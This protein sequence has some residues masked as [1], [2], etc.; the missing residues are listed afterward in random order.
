LKNSQGVAFSRWHSNIIKMK[1]ADEKQTA[2]NAMAALKRDHLSYVEDKIKQVEQNNAWKYSLSKIISAFRGVLKRGCRSA[3]RTWHRAVMLMDAADRQRNDER[4]QFKKNVRIG[5]ARLVRFINRLFRN[6]VGRMFSTWNINVLRMNDM[7]ALND[8]SETRDNILMLEMRNENSVKLES[9]RKRFQE[10]TRELRMNAKTLERKVQ[11]QDTLIK[12][13]K[14]V[15]ETTKK[16]VS[17]LTEKLRHAN[18]HRDR[19]L[20]EVKRGQEDLQLFKQ[21]HGGSKDYGSVAEVEF[22][23][24]QQLSEIARLRSLWVSAENTRVEEGKRCMGLLVQLKRDHEEKLAS[25]ES[26]NSMLLADINQKSNTIETMEAEHEFEQRRLQ[27]K[28]VTLKTSFKERLQAAHD[29]L[30]K[31]RT[32]EIDALERLHCAEKEKLQENIVNIKEQVQNNV[33]FMA[34]R[35]I[36]SIFASK[37]RVGQLAKALKKW[38]CAM[39]A[40]HMQTQYAQKRTHDHS[41]MA[42]SMCNI[43][44]LQ[45]Q[46]FFFQNWAKKSFQLRK[47][48]SFMRILLARKHRS[49]FE[50]TWTQW[51]FFC[52]KVSI[53]T[54]YVGDI[55]SLKAEYGQYKQRVV[56]NRVLAYLG[57]EKR[58]QMTRCILQWRQYVTRLRMQRNN[59]RSIFCKVR[60]HCL[61]ESFKRLLYQKNASVLQE[62]FDNHSLSMKNLVLKNAKQTA[63]LR[64][65]DILSCL[66]RK[67]EN[68]QVSTYF[69]HIK[70]EAIRFQRMKSFLS[71]K[72]LARHRACTARPF[73]ILFRGCMREKMKEKSIR[74]QKQLQADMEFEFETQ[75]HE[76]INKYE[77]QL[78][79]S[80]ELYDQ[81]EKA[82]KEDFESQIIQTKDRFEEKILQRCRVLIEQFQY[83]QE[84]RITVRIFQSWRTCSRQ[85][86]RK[87]F[88]MCTM[89]SQFNNTLLL[90]GMRCWKDMSNNIHLFKKAELNAKCW[91]DMKKQAKQTQLCRLFR[92]FHY[93][94]LRT[95]LH[96]LS[97]RTKMLALIQDSARA[98]KKLEDFHALSLEN[99][100]SET[101]SELHKQHAAILTS[102]EEAFEQRLKNES[103]AAETLLRK[104]QEGAEHESIRLQ[105]EH[106]RKMEELH[107]CLSSKWHEEKTALVLRHQEEQEKAALVASIRYSDVE[108]ELQRA[109]HQRQLLEVEV[110]KEKR[111]SAK[112]KEKLETVIAR[113]TAS[114]SSKVDI[115]ELQHSDAI[116]EIKS[117]HRQEMINNIQQLQEKHAHELKL[118]KTRLEGLHA[119]ALAS[120]MASFEKH[121]SAKLN[122][123]FSLQK[124]QYEDT[125]VAKMKALVETHDERLR[126]ALDRA[127]LEHDIDTTRKLEKQKGEM[128]AHIKLLESNHRSEV[129][130][131]DA[132][133]QRALFSLKQQCQCE[134]E[135]M[136]ATYTAQKN[137]LELQCAQTLS[138]NA[139]K[140]QEEK[141][142]FKS[143]SQINFAKK[144]QT[145]EDEYNR[146]TELLLSKNERECKEYSERLICMRKDFSK[147]KEEIVTKMTASEKAAIERVRI[148]FES[149]LSLQKYQAE[150]RAKQN[151]NKRLAEAIA[152]L[153]SNIRQLH[154]DLEQQRISSVAS[155]EELKLQLKREWEE[156]LKLSLIER[157]DAVSKALITKFT[158][159]KTELEHK[160][161]GIYLK[162]EIAL[163]NVVANLEA[164]QK[165]LISE[166]QRTAELH[167]SKMAD[168]RSKLQTWESEMDLERHATREKME[169]MERTFQENIKQAV[170]NITGLKDREI[171]EITERR[172]RATHEHEKEKQ[173]LEKKLTEELRLAA[174]RRVQV[175]KEEAASQ[176]LVAESKWKSKLEEQVKSH[177]LHIRDLEQRF[178]FDLA[179]AAVAQTAAISR[180]KDAH[181]KSM[182]KLKLDHA[183]VLEDIKK[184]TELAKRGLQQRHSD[185]VAF[186]LKTMEASAENKLREKTLAL[187]QALQEDARREKE[188][189][190]H[191]LNVEWT[192]KLNEAMCEAE[193]KRTAALEQLQQVHKEETKSALINL[194]MQQECV[195]NQ[196]IDTTTARLQHKVDVVVEEQKH[197]TT[198]FAKEAQDMAR[199]HQDQVTRLQKELAEKEWKIQEGIQ[200]LDVQNKRKGLEL[201]SLSLKHVH[202]IKEMRIKLSKEH[203]EALIN[204]KREHAILIDAERERA[205]SESKIA[206]EAKLKEARNS[207]E[208]KFSLSLKG[209]TQRYEKSLNE[210]DADIGRLNATVSTLQALQPENEHLRK[211]LLTLAQKI[212]TLESSLASLDAEKV[213]VET[214]RQ[215]DIDWHKSE[216]ERC[217]SLWDAEKKQLQK[218]FEHDV[219]MCEEKNDLMRR[220]DL[221]DQAKEVRKHCEQESRVKLDVL[222]RQVGQQFI[223]EQNVMNENWASL[224]A[225]LA[226]KQALTEKDVSN[227]VLRMSQERSKLQVLLNRERALAA[228]TLRTQELTR[229]KQEVLFQKISQRYRDAIHTLYQ[230]KFAGKRTLT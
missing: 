121:T 52:E 59:L 50:S 183:T 220:K 10:D 197:Q 158:H 40:L 223:H 17:G 70:T 198:Q 148:E 166:L 150:D 138:D 19:L 212:Q 24:V 189:L 88:L 209:I 151:T 8:A 126:Q 157:E 218:Q 129:D 140:L 64:Q 131:L 219:Q 211:E 49:I 190:R 61:S 106:K 216:H 161:V 226:E 32:R 199:K 122:A 134:K 5:R 83:K 225:K 133:H 78:K 81:Q 33:K 192:T 98:K 41:R 187:K 69:N 42:L 113:V 127:Q 21:I 202:E 200:E 207:Y 128:E 162:K 25:L 196:S 57:L 16:E 152:P 165:K 80:Q 132:G 101:K 146:K 173:H 230:D 23:K 154:V 56:E 114:C 109:K 35:R 11:Q 31:T 135:A 27:N 30:F 156:R 171:Q 62:T 84:A 142:A 217:V 76:I 175:A 180:E 214:Q 14:S 20:E 167:A 181:D 144:L 15:A 159:E 87:T 29:D 184:N 201:Q 163:K 72:L 79:L 85:R 97:T 43:R 203:S 136:L 13:W 116:A 92:F 46:A 102:K 160:L 55:D 60:K 139:T 172:L 182:E 123:S 37:D 36:Y 6:K 51:R 96:Q 90:K 82:M 149:K 34:G 99:A 170:E 73:Q 22:E 9:Q 107:Q 103:I 213:K 153:E 215:K 100:V 94:T 188:Q 66:L 111:E 164:E 120:S 125:N 224:I 18:D 12:H 145:K 65:Q 177:Q 2:D 178:K 204:L 67:I 108:K 3:F 26:K 115:L 58:S 141:N 206:Y 118:E 44:S 185:E 222:M 208:N 77:K 130:A 147:E 221:H 191:T 48:K 28:I 53:S 1:F 143:D 137:S 93:G 193:K 227:L 112:E 186:K 7:K 71:R 105:S 168:S 174:D 195:H 229:K 95:A 63:Y 39:S 228:Q 91:Q 54:R 119:D 110:E 194:Q 179:N 86:S 210:R 124:A 68:K 4:V 104:T 205:F 75:K 155:K 176:L 45:N 89:I 169:S 117:K 47:A 38:V 74:E